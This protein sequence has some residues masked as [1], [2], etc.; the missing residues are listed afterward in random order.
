MCV[1]E[2]VLLILEFS[3]TRNTAFCIDTAEPVV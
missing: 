3:S 1:R 2:W